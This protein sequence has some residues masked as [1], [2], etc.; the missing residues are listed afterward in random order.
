MA[1]K[2]TQSGPGMKFSSKYLGPYTV[3]KVLRNDRY[4]VHKAGDHEGPRQTSTSVDHMKPWKI[5]PT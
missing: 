2:R 1:I 4:L 5:R 3:V